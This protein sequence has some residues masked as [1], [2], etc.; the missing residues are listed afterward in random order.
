[1][2]VIRAIEQAAKESFIEGGLSRQSE[3]EALESERDEL[4]GFV[5]GYY[6]ERNEALGHC[7]AK[8]I[9]INEQAEHI[10]RLKSVLEHVNISSGLKPDAWKRVMD[11][12]ADVYNSTPTQSLA[13]HDNKVAAG[14]RKE[15]ADWIGDDDLFSA[16]IALS[17]FKPV[18]LRK[19]GD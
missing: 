13:I 9:K 1:M 18:Q 3:I 15:F 7:E 6:D 17:N 10:E 8:D 4:K 2:N 11:K 16:S 19:E 14:A 12:V 5:D